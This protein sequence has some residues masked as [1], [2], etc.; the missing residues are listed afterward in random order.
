MENETREP[1]YWLGFLER[2]EAFG[3]TKAAMFIKGSKKSNAVSERGFKP[4]VS[5]KVFGVLQSHLWK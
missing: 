2:V 1:G 5:K 4:G 3:N